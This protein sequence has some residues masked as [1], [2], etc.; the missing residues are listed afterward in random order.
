MEKLNKT[1][2]Q[3]ANEFELRGG[4]DITGF[5]LLGHG[6]E[7]AEASGVSLRIVF[8]QIP[9]LNGA[10]EYAKQGCF[11]GGA[12]D[13]KMHLEN[14]VILPESLDEPDQMLLFDPQTSGGLLLG[15][16]QEKLAV[17]L[18]RAEEIGQSVWVIGEVC[19]GR[20]IEVR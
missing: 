17:L 20:G 19:D 6:F 11:P 2:S 12:F 10:R 9:L 16:P 4:T 14:H 1:A 15:V 7:M 18:K 13:N 8:D 5:G 3:L